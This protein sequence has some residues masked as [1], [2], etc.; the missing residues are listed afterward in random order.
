MIQFLVEMATGQG[1]GLYDVLTVH[2]DVRIASV[3]FISG[4]SY[5]YELSSHTKPVLLSESVAPPR[6]S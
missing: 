3:D 6:L 2:A 1:D 4:I 5:Q